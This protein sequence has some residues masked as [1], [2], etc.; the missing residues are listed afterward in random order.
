M[1]H[2][3][4]LNSKLTQLLKE[5]LG[6]NT[7]TVMITTIHATTD[8]SKVTETSLQ[9]AS[10]ARAV[11]GKVV[12]ND[13][14]MADRWIAETDPEILRLKKL[15]EERSRDFA[16]LRVTQLNRPPLAPHSSTNGSSAP[17]SAAPSPAGSRS[18]S[19]LRVLQKRP[20]EPNQMAVPES[21]SSGPDNSALK[22]RIS[23]LELTNQELKEDV[24]RK[25]RQSADLSM[26]LK[27][28]LEL[29]QQQNKALT[30]QLND[31]ANDKDA[32]IAV[33]NDRL[34][35]LQAE[36]D[37]QRAASAGDADDALNATNAELE[38]AKKSA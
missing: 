13:L 8:Y 23:D 21:K 36:L 32:Q 11:R 31:V 1:Q 6:G 19:P 25:S 4:Y 9:Y 27:K 3:P 22:N 38:R 26:S 10:W 29:I 18:S 33:L 16:R 37:A 34:A 28:S 7:K 30:D 2:V 35:G 14:N 5:S 17:S 20:S 24:A 15:L 12:R